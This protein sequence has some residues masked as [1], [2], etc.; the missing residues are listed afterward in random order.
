MTFSDWRYRGQWTIF[1]IIWVSICL[2]VW[3][4][5]EIRMKDVH[6]K[7]HEAYNID[8][9]PLITP[10]EGL[11]TLFSTIASFHHVSVDSLEAMGIRRI[12]LFL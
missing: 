7:N 12:I 2:A 6:T 1:M 9:E 3:T 4:P 8:K 11:K 5:R 10:R